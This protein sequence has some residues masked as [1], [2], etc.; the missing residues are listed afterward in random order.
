MFFRSREFTNSGSLGPAK[1]RIRG[2]AEFGNL[3]AVRLAYLD[4]FR[5]VLAYFLSQN[6]IHSTRRALFILRAEHPPWFGEEAET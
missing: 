4:L 5:L 3:E 1:S 6:T 2:C